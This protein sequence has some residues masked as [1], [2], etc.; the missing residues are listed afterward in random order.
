[1]AAANITRR[2]PAL[3]IAACGYAG[4]FLAFVLVEQPGLGI[5]H[6]FYLPICLVAL[7]TDAFGGAAAGLLAAGLYCL[8]VVADPAI[9]SHDALTTATGI[10]AVTFAL[11]GAI[12]GLYA[13]RNR[14][15]VARLREHA[16]EDFV[17]G[18]A[19]VRAFDEA[20]RGRVERATPFT[21]VLA[22]VDQLRRVN[23]VH[24]HAAGDAALRAVA[25]ALSALAVPDDVVARVG[26]D[27]FALLT[28]LA[29]EEIPTLVARLNASLA[30][31]TLTI[32]AAATAFPEHAETADDLYRRADD[33]LFTAKLLAA[34][35]RQLAAV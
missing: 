18:I 22:D 5:G 34:N 4:V 2:G 31:E 35:R 9:P 16:A 21:L 12:V 23:E 17:T 1:M 24:G 20:L 29:P 14:H 30:S 27:E 8:A 3:L 6:F 26:G 32:T 33:R 7:A 15:L 19:N 25:S 28:S 10:R 11:V 13:A